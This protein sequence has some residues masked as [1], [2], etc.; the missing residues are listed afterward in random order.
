MDALFSG[1]MLQQTVF[2]CQ[3]SKCV[4]QTSTGGFRTV[5]VMPVCVIEYISKLDSLV[6]VYGT[7]H[8]TGLSYQ[9]AAF[10]QYDGKI[11]E[12]VLMVSGELPVYPFAHILFGKTVFPSVHDFRLSHYSK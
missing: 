10:F 6:P 3:L 8:Q 1:R 5:T 9:R 2:Q 12:P 11:S 4:F 7:F